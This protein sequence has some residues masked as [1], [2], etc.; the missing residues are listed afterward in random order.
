MSKAATFSEYGGPEVVKIVAVPEPVP[1][2]GQ[3]RLEVRSAGVNPFDW[4]LVAGYLQEFMPLE[5][6]SGLGMDVAGVVDEVGEGVTDLVVGDQVLGQAPIGA[7]AESVIAD[8]ARLVRRPE[9]LAWDVAGGIAAIGGTAWGALEHLAIGEGDTLLIHAAAGGVGLIATQL[10]VMRGARVIGTASESNHGFLT[11]L[12][13]VPVLYGD[14]L[15]GAVRAVAPDGVD[16]VLDASGRGELSDSIELA[17]GTDR[18]ATIAAPDA[19]DHGVTL[20]VGDSTEFAPAITAVVDLIVAGDVQ[21]PIHRAYPLEQIAAALADSQ[22]GH[23][24]GK[25]VITVAPR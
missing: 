23:L 3:V 13:A 11:S 9:G 17:G 7:F 5:L 21:L 6:P 8:P 16:A 19:E 24:S 18:V 12:G 14:G 15:V 4:K 10:A 20:L 25:I 2:P 22:A 1:G